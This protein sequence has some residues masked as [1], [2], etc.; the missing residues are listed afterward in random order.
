[1]LIPS[2]V[3][4]LRNGERYPLTHGEQTRD[5][6]HVDDV[7]RAVVAAIDARPAIYNI[8]SGVE[9]RIKDVC[10]EIARAIGVSK[11]L[12]GF[13]EKELRPDEATRYVLDVQRARVGL[14]WRTSINIER[15]VATL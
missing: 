1:M 4:A 5:L 15:G 14:G 8:A 7:A 2:L 6:V 9:T 11:D 12:L 13:G 3:R 10:L